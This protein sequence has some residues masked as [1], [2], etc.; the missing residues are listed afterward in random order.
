MSN[1][2]NNQDRPWYR[3]SRT[4][5]IVVGL[6]FIVA[7]AGLAFVPLISALLG[8]GGGVKTEGIDES[9]LRSATTDVDGEW[10]ASTKPGPNQ[11]SAGFTFFEILPAEKKVTSGSTRSVSG[12]VTVE[13]GTLRSGEITV[14]MATLTTDSDVRDNNVRSKI[15]STDQFPE[16]TFTLT[17]PA[18]VSQVPDDGTVTQVE[19]TGDLTIR[20]QTREV[21]QPFNVARS[22]EN[23][24]VAGDIP[25]KRS[26]YGV[27]TPELVAAK[28][29][30][31][32]EVN[33]KV[34]LQ[35][36]S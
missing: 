14:D 1:V 13:G 27:E 11:T 34:N 16:A 4:P 2:N 10:A 33:I 3:V 6:I 31:D 20:G 35:K 15:L 23:V 8:G 7:L 17:K 24:L 28:I 26:E 12:G 19:L 21:S 29:A 18:D 22:G 32:G 9:H 30:D 5:L 25:I 36:K